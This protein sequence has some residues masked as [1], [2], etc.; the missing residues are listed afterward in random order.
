MKE[1]GSPWIRFRDLARF[2]S[3]GRLNCSIDKV[4]G[5]V[6]TRRPSVKNQRYAE[7]IK[8]GDQ[9]LTSVQRLSRVIG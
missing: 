2:I 1:F 4:G 5:I 7:V 8:T 9:V 3:T 6:E